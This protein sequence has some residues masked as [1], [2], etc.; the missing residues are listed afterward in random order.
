MRKTTIRFFKY[1]GT[2]IFKFKGRI[3]D[4][5][6]VALSNSRPN[7]KMQ[8]LIKITPKEDYKNRNIDFR[9][10]ADDSNFRNTVKSHCIGRRL[11]IS[12]SIYESRDLANIFHKSFADTVENLSI[13]IETRSYLKGIE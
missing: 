9:K 13:S 8:L 1:Y 5:L 12:E 2:I 6:R 10:I 7:L 3:L 11:G 4:G